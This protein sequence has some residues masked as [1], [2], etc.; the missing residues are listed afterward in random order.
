MPETPSFRNPPVIEVSFGIQFGRLSQWQTRHFG[1]FWNRVKDEFPGSADAP[2]LEFANQATPQIELL[3]MPP[4]RRV[5]FASPDQIFL[6]Q[7]QDNRFNFNWRKLGADR[8]YPRFR[9]L[10]PQFQKWLAVHAEFLREKKLEDVKPTRYELTYVNHID[11][12][13]DFSGALERYVKLFSWS[14]VAPQFLTAP[15]TAT[16]AW[17]FQMPDQFGIMTANLTHVKTIDN[18]DLLVLALSCFGDRVE[19]PQDE[20]FNAAHQSIV[21]GFTDLTTELAHNSWGREK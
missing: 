13:G 4:L 10:F 6:L 8:E 7:V 11:L 21:F 16:S 9:S 15:I 12:S 5:L 20:W 19:I 1:D 3:V 14:N 2:P 17:Q 18:K